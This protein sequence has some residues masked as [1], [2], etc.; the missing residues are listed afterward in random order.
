MKLT[1]ALSVVLPLLLFEPARQVWLFDDFE[2][3]EHVAAHELSWV[4]LGDDLL[5]GG[6]KLA[7]ETV[8]RG[9]SGHALRLEGSV[10]T[11]PLAFTGAWAPL[12]GQSRPVDLAAF[13]T[14]RFLARGEG[15]FQAGLRSG[16]PSGMANFMGSFTLG[17][18]WRPFEIPFEH[19]APVGPGSSGARFRPEE[20]HWLGITTAPGAHGAFRL[21]I[22][23]VELVSSRNGHNRALPVAQPGPARTVRVSFTEGPA[24]NDWRELA[25]DPAGDGKRPSLPDVV[26]LSVIP[27]DANEG[28]ERVWFRIGLKDA[29]PLPWLGL[30]LVFDVDG[31]TGNGMP[32]WGANTA[33][34]FDRLATVWLFRTGPTY[35]GVAGTADVAAV[36]K[37]EFMTNGLELAV[38]VDRDARAILVGV[39]RSVLGSGGQSR[40]LAAVGSAM[41]HNDDVP[42]TGAILFPR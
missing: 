30:N 12:D 42:D 9:G 6:S 20:V 26:S 24:G 2:S 16:A 38:A 5:G 28:S 36:A 29:P 1:L 32:W 7:L 37:G 41:A 31:D 39:P 4:A 13:D 19:L 3:A 21:E 11:E 23:D 33:F 15:T 34:Q 40:F 17:P 25:R 18:D 27:D 8:P 22:D 35:Q 14:L 10:G